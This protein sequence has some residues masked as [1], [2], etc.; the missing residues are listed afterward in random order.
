MRIRRSGDFQVTFLSGN[1]KSDA[2]MTCNTTDR[3]VT[4]LTS[5]ITCFHVYN[6]VYKLKINEGDGTKVLFSAVL[7]SF[8]I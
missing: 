7:I 4:V 1:H 8:L 2:S 5:L 6:T 3:Q